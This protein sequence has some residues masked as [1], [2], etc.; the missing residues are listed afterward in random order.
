MSR[1]NIRQGRFGESSHPFMVLFTFNPSQAF[2]EKA[3]NPWTNDN[4]VILH[5][6]VNLE[7]MLIYKELTVVEDALLQ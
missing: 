5:S 6:C 2:S 3:C 7:M 1:V 4:A